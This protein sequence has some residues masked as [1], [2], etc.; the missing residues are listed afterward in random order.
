VI[1]RPMSARA[2]IE[3]L[4]DA[5]AFDAAEQDGAI[6]FRPRGGAAVGEL[7]EDD[8][9][10]P[11]DG[12]PF[13]LSRAQE[14]ELPREAAIGYSD[15]GADFR[16]AVA[17]SRRLVGGSAR[18]AH[19]DLAAVMSDSAAAR[20]AEIW[21]QDVWAGR[22]SA[23]FAL[24]PSLVA[25]T[26]GDVVGL[27]LNG[28]RRLLE[29]RELVDTERRAVK[30]RSIDPEV[31]DLPLALPARRAPEP[32][33]AIGPVH[34]LALDLPALDGAEPPVLLRVAVFA[35]PWP[36]AVAIWSSGDGESFALVAHSSAP[37]IMGETLDELPAGPTGRWQRARVRVKLYGGALSSLSNGALFAGGNAAALRRGDGAW[38]IVQ[39]G[40]AVLVGAD[41]YELTRWLRGQAGSEQAIGDPLPA[42]APFVV[43]DPHVVAVARGLDALDR[44]LQL[45]IVSAGRDHGDQAAFALEATPRST[46]LR[47]LAPVHLR[48]T[49]AAE[50]VTLTWI[51]R[52]RVNGDSWSGEVPLGEQSEAYEVDILDG[53]DVLRTL[54]AS[55]PSVLYAAADELADFGAP[56]SSLSVRVVQLS[57][58]VGRGF[59]A[60]AVLTM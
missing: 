27:T 2:A 57:A 42:G 19:A 38:E 26:P 43:L 51:R 28:R 30:A 9:A 34:A 29:L 55:Q 18:I 53:M 4:A 7:V 8:L 1:D 36:G 17:S 23:E 49:R 56:Q 20:R 41:I 11:D 22:E 59:A 21:L 45:R 46:A 35:E 31:F 48:A 24:P 25:L 47:P 10:L 33:P 52:T 12:A 40:D 37:S 13:R 3:P 5:F 58:T 15:V 32:P 44:A 39:F 54:S 16:R 60:E 14:T 6:V 50:G